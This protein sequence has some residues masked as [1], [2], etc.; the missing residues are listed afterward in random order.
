[1][2]TFGGIEQASGALDAARYGLNVVSQN[3]ANADTPGYTRQAAQQVSVGDMAGVPSLY[4]RRAG[5]GGVSITGTARLND[6]IVDARARAE[7]ARGALADTTA[8]SLAAIENV[9]PEPS[10]NGLSEQLNDFWNSWSAVANDPGSTAPRTVLLQ[11]A[12]TVA[13]TLN[14]MSTSLG[15]VATSTAE[16]LGQDVGA[17]NSAAGQLALLNGQ[18]AVASASGANANTLLDQRDVLLGRLSTLVGGVATINANGSADVSV[19]GQSLVSGSSTTGLTVTGTNQVTVG[20]TAVT[21]VGGSA[22]AEV[23]A[24]TTTIPAY[25]AQLDAVANALASTVNGAQGAGYDLAGNPG[26]PL[27]A[28]SGASAVAVAITDPAALAASGMP[29][30][31]L[32]GSNALSLAGLGNVAGGPDRAYATLVGSIGSASALAEQQ[33]ITQ[34][35][36]T[37]SVDAMRTSVSGVNY[38]EEVSNMLTFQHAYNASARVL[39]TLDGMLDTL[40]NH[41]GLVGLS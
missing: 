28:G 19:A 39:T 16:S 9:F 12:A 14:A 18:I 36:V 17:A 21:L 27:F 8:N 13:S 26:G 1:M 38:D 3:I 37:T 15:D 29:G 23:L 40:I 33:Q 22:A 10:D 34:S 2:S 31:N 32:D 41:T 35:A 6:P 30:G 7:H 11:R 20:A 25:Q 4:S 5:D 24:L